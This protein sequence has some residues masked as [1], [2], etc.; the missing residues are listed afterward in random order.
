M[1]DS[2]DLQIC[3]VSSRGEGPEIV[4]VVELLV[5]SPGALGLDTE[6]TGLDP[7]T[8]RV[9]L[10]Q[11]ASDSIALVVD[12]EAFREGGER[13]VDWTL[14]GLRE[15]RQLLTGPKP[16]VIQNAAFDLNFLRGEGLEVGG[17]VFDTMIASKV[18]NNGHP[19]RNGLGAIVNRELGWE[20]PKELQKANWAGEISTEMVL[21]AARD[22]SALPQLVA[23][24]TTKLKRSK[25]GDVTLW[26][27]FRLECMCLRPISAMQ[28][29]GF[30]FDRARGEELLVALQA[31]AEGLMDE[32]LRH[33]Q[34]KL[35]ARY[36][37]EPGQWLP[38]D[39]DGSFNTRT[40]ETGAIRLGTKQY[41]GFNPRSPQQ[42][43]KKLAALGVILPPNEKGKASMD[44]NLLA[45]LRQENELIDQY[46]VWKE[47][48]TQVTHIEKLL[49]S[50]GPDGR[51][52]ANYRQVGTD[53]GRLSCAEPNLQQVPG[54][55][56]FRSLFVPKEGY[57]LVVADFSQIELRVAAE[58]SEEPRMLEAYRAGRDLHTET[59]AL[60][61]K[62]DWDAV[63]K[64]E[65]RSAKAA[66][67]GLLFGAGPATLRKQAMSQYGLDLDLKEAKS[68]VDGFRKAYP[69]LYEWQVNE[70]ESTTT[71]VFTRYGR[72]RILVGFN[73]KFTTRINTQVQG[74]AGDIAKIAIAKL[75][76][77]LRKAPDEAT[78][79]AMVHDEIVLE[80]RED[81]VDTW[82]VRLQGAME[83]AGGVVCKLV[84]IVAEVSTG[85]TWAEAK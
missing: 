67:F 55:K 5:A 4:Q 37:T 66:N 79:I 20:L 60:L 53:T 11:V 59:A 72:R 83:G 65:R 38:L 25:V 36:P 24:L 51:I 6:T 22:A 34:A 30:G 28:W 32:L 31:K 42:M 69:K 3:Y 1:S 13:Q 15:L 10:I 62:K 74:T 85:D 71:S 18:L 82:S 78:L 14:P 49:G 50:I 48:A 77:H 52:H 16:K 81:V 68:L 19:N 21:Y 12:L 46:L 7:I 61:T 63:T 39:A 17:H 40:K 8:K 58:L 56:E 76:E 75:W 45:F 23:P 43:V 54:D 41:A 9:R 35:K 2:A 29:H 64:E 26:D 33:M 70:G 84:P 80:V 44:Q 27:V 47:A 73:D 57:K